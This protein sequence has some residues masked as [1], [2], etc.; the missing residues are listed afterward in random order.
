MIPDDLT[1]PENLGILGG[2]V[3][4]IWGS[5]KFIRSVWGWLRLE[6]LDR[7]LDRLCETQ[8]AMQDEIGTALEDAQTIKK[9]ISEIKDAVHRIELVLMEAGLAKKTVTLGDD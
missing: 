1:K 4:G 5:R 3:G 2:I 7:R 8:A 9:D 6:H